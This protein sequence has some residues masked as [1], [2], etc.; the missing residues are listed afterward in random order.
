MKKIGIAI[1]AVA[2]AVG[3]IVPNLFSFG[4]MFDFPVHFGSVEGSGQMVSEVREVGTFHGVDVGG[5]FKVEIVAG[6]QTGVEIEADDNLLPLISTHVDH[7]GILHIESE[8]RIKSQ[9]DIRIRVTTPDIDDLDVSGAANVTV[10][11][12]KNDGIN[13]DASGASHIKVSGETAKLTIDIS[14]AT[15]VDAEDLEAVNAHV[16]A[17]GASNAKVNVSGKLGADLSGASH[18]TYSG[19]PT[20]V[21]KKTSGAASVTAAK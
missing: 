12:L 8:R 21:E 19:S 20:S 5:V 17:S 15:R 7:R 16:D 18:V 2:L 9:N 1:F 14:G 11:G 10:T 6:S 4:R 13:V 3:L